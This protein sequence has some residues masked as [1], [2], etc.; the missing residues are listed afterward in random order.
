MDGEGNPI[1]F[2]WE[3]T[4]GLGEIASELSSSTELVIAS[5]SL[6]P[7]FTC[8]QYP[9]NLEQQIHVSLA[10]DEGLLWSSAS[11]KM[12]LRFALSPGASVGD[13]DNGDSSNNGTS[14]SGGRASQTLYA[15]V[16]EE[17]V[18]R[19]LGP[20]PF[21]MPNPEGGTMCGMSYDAPA[22]AATP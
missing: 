7:P 9:D 16:L 3:K 21:A 6:V 4:K 20:C 22:I 2:H 17:R 1:H 13:C 8:V 5:N 19:L 11:A 12:T 10:A 15:D 18:Q 14:T